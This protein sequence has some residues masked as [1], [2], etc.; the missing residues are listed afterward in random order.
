M[1]KDNYK[2]TTQEAYDDFHESVENLKKV[3]LEQ[4]EPLII[5][6]ADRMV[7]VMGRIK[8]IWRPGR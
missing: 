8:K 4:A 5:A 7:K 3:L 1:N 6:T 2:T